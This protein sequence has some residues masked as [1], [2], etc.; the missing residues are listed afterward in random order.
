MRRTR[1][2]TKATVFLVGLASLTAPVSAGPGVQ[3]VPRLENVVIDGQPDDWGERGLRANLLAPVTGWPAQPAV[4]RSLADHD[5]RIRVGWDE[6]N[7]RGRRGVRG[8][9]LLRPG[10]ATAEARLI[11]PPQTC[12]AAMSIRIERLRV[13][14][15]GEP[16]HVNAT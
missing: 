14:T 7:R 13:S 16:S 4:L 6:A 3:D 2:R 8:Y 12:R 10:R 5:V 9:H 1:L 15:R 11:R